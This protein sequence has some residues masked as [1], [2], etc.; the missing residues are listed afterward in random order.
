MRTSAP[1]RIGEVPPPERSLGRDAAPFGE[2]RGG[3]VPGLGEP[4]D[5]RVPKPGRRPT[6]RNNEIEGG[7]LEA[8]TSPRVCASVIGVSL[9]L[10]AYAALTGSTMIPKVQRVPTAARTGDPAGEDAGVSRDPAIDSVRLK[11]LRESALRSR[12]RLVADSNEVRSI[13]A[14]VEGV[15]LRLGWRTEMALAPP[16]E[17]PG[18]WTEL[19]GYRAILQL[20]PSRAGTPSVFPSLVQWIEEISRMPK[21]VEVVQLAFG[22]DHER[23]WSARVTIEMLGLSNDDDGKTPPE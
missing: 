1:I 15:A 9:V 4:A 23:R 17:A 13:L 5:L 19:K 3:E 11:T 10:L 20:T 18:G 16:V 14:A 6:L 7:W 22:R 12:T 2:T 8:A 21:H